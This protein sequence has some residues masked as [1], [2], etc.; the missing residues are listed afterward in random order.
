[1]NLEQWVFRSRRAQGLPDHVENPVV[2]AHVAEL[3]IDEW[4][5]VSSSPGERQRRA[6]RS[7]KE[8]P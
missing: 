2:L 1:M 8:P 6:T 4:Q 7:P 3:L 5:H